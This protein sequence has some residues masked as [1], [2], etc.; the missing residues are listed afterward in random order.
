MLIAE[1][2]NNHFGSLKKAK[3]MIRI[4]KTCGA[5]LI[6]GQAFDPE[7]LKHGSMN[8]E[9]YK[10]CAFNFEEYCELIEYGK[11]F[12]IDVFFSIFSPK[13]RNLE[14]KQ[15]WFKLA[16]V[17]TKGG[18][19]DLKSEDNKNTFVSVPGDMDYPDFK[20]ANILYVSEYLPEDPILDF[21]D[22]LSDYY[23]RRVG[24]S[25]HTIG[26]GS[27][28]KAIKEY[29]A[30]IIEKH[31][32]LEQNVKFHDKVFRDTV[33][34]AMPSELEALSRFFHNLKAV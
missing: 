27:C 10:Q 34:G 8:Y 4:A 3:E 19:Y 11:D 18:K 15:K 21:I 13:F 7:D 12:E 23:D 24:Y 31:F 28:E 25:D 1:I 33:H 14:L 9:F 26:I 17:Q 2:G 5:D 29:N 30:I 6:K 32:T 20:K 22:V 16:G